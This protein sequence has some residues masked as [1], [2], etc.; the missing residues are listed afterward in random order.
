[1]NSK[2][3][4]L[5]FL[6]LGLKR[7][8]TARML[9]EYESDAQ[10]DPNARRTAIA[11]ILKSYFWVSNLSAP[12]VFLIGT[13][14]L[15]LT[16]KSH[17]LWAACLLLVSLFITQSSSEGTLS[18]K[19]F[20]TYKLFIGVVVL[21]SCYFSIIFDR[22]GQWGLAHNLDYFVGNSIYLV[23]GAIGL[24]ALVT[25]GIDLFKTKEK[26]T[27][28]QRLLF[29]VGTIAIYLSSNDTRPVQ[30][31]K[32]HIIQLSLTAILFLTSFIKRKPALA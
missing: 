5:T 22:S 31:S 28:V 13:V 29:V 26:L 8:R 19:A 30:Y 12:L 11:R 14:G 27:Q 9:E 18:F 4:L 23:G 1:M 16:L 7:A 2:D 21:L 6:S 17:W 3:T 10:A 25:A 32:A 15:I 20:K 24:V